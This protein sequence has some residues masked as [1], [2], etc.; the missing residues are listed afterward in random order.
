MYFEGLFFAVVFLNQNKS[1]NV[2]KLMQLCNFSQ[3]SYQNFEI[4]NQYSDKEVNYVCFFILKF[5]F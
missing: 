1:I 3:L 5:V 4:S 2:K